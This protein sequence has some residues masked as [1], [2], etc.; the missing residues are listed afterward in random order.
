[1]M[2]PIEL[3]QAIQCL[4]SGEIIITPSE[5]CYG[6]SCDAKNPQAVAKLNALKGRAG[7]ALSVLVAD[8]REIGEIGVVNDV[9]NKLSRAFHPGQLNL[10]VDL[11]DPAKYAYLSQNGLAWRIPG[12]PV[13]LELTK[14]F[15]PITTTSANRHGKAPIYQYNQ[16][17]AEFGTH[18]CA[19]LNV[20]DLDPS[21]APSTVYD[22]RSDKI[23][24]H[25]LVTAEMIRFALTK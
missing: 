2:K 10:I 11:R 7:M 20:G 23:V 6:F 14:A 19:I 17:V 3:S 5:S 16:A 18:A 24:R 8:I 21:V 9:A 1:M 13:L 12:H 25:G 4:R 22:T 15:G